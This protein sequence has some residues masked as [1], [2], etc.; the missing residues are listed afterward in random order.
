MPAA[1]LDAHRRAKPAQPPQGALRQHADPGHAFEA[2]EPAPAHRPAQQPERG[3]VEAELGPGAESRRGPSG[4]ARR[5]QVEIGH[6]AERHPAFQRRMAGNLENDLAHFLPAEAGPPALPA[7]EPDRPPGI[8]EDRA[9]HRFAAAG[10]VA[11]GEG[12]VDRAHFVEARREPVAHRAAQ[13]RHAARAGDDSDARRLRGG[14][15]RADPG[16][17]IARVGKIEIVAAR[18]DAGLSDAIILI[19]ERSRRVDD[20]PRPERRQRIR[21]IAVAIERE[22]NDPERHM[23]RAEGFGLGQAAPGRDHRE[24]GAGQK[25]RHLRAEAA[26]AAQDQHP[27]RVHFPPSVLDPCLCRP[28]GAHRGAA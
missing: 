12:D 16:D 3:I 26:I 23:A 5:Q 28:P 22:R 9:R 25:L 15:E 19:L 10:A 6:L 18:G 2:P 11:R 24:T 8:R 13:R 21:E 17:E 20:Q 4:M 1:K 7:P 27:P 14:I